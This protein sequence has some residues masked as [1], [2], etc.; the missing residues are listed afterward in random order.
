MTDERISDRH[1]DRVA[2][3]VTGVGVGVAVFMLTW[4]VGNRVAD[5]LWTPPT[6]PIMAIALAAVTGILVSVR[7]GWRLSRR[8]PT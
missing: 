4:L 7:Q 2:A 1:A 8:F 6:G 3:W 5:L